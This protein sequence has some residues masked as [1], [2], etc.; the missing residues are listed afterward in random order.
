MSIYMNE[1]HTTCAYCTV[2]GC[3]N[4]E[5]DNNPKN[6]PMHCDEYMDTVFTPY[7]DPETHRFYQATRL[8]VGTEFE[9]KGTPRLRI[10]VDMCKYMGYKK[11]GIAFCSMF[12][13]E[14][15]EYAKIFRLNGIECVTANCLNG[16][17]N[18]TEHDVPL[19]DVCVK[20]GFDPA[21]NPIGQAVL[22]NAQKTEFNI[23][24]GLCLGHDSLFIKNSD[25]MCTVVHIKDVAT[26]HRPTAAL[27]LYRNYPE[28]FTGPSPKDIREAQ[29]KGEE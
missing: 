25:A 17:F 11:V 2:K 20:E 6:C 15:E 10:I 8:A 9:H 19:P 7:E 26:N 12:I 5:K 23:V 13:R 18:I 27:K 29:E 24:M 28:I 16:G 3:R 21:C 14:A 1:L 4:G 22:L